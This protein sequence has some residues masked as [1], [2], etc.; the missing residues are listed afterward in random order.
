[1]L[2][3]YRLLGIGP[4]EDDPDV[5]ENA[6]DRQMGHV[7]TFQSGKHSQIS[8][9]ILN[10]LAAAKI[11]LLNPEKKAAYDQ[12]LGRRVSE[13]PSP[14]SQPVVNAGHCTSD[15]IRRTQIIF[16]SWKTEKQL[17]E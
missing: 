15:A 13:S 12:A 8:Q 10:E 1:M 17:I 14:L 4:Y 7:R 11:T 6:A 3:H 16:S 5:I 9:R 2:F